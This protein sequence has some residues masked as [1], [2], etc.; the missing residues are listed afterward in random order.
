M[1]PDLNGLL[2][3]LMAAGFGAGLVCLAVYVHGVT[4]NPGKPPNRARRLGA[5]LRSPALSGRLGGG[6]LVGVL[7]LVLTRWPVLAFGLSA[8]VV[9]WPQMFGGQRAEQNQIVRLEGLVMWTESLRDTITARASLEQAIKA[10]TTDQ[11]APA[12]IRAALIRL[13]GLIRTR[14]PLERALLMLSADLD[15]ASADKVIGALILNTKQRGT[16]LVTILTSL[17]SS[18]RAELDQRR[19]VSAGRA[20]MRRSV[21]LVVLITIGFGAFLVLFS[22]SYVQPY[23]SLGGQAALAV[24]VALFAAGFWWM[25]R[26]A[27]GEPATRFL[28]VRQEVRVEDADLRVVAHLTGLDSAQAQQLTANRAAGPADRAHAS[29]AQFE[30]WP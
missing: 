20:S 23:A 10:T 6:V 18:A 11:S 8:L 28:G 7:T 3:A 29:A 24:V 14:V 9:F 30:V 19:R 17:A 1:L 4:P 25:R 26:L 21:Q 5:R 2:A 15:D 16:G 27:G 22:R 12:A 13:R